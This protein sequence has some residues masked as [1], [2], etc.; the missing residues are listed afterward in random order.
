MKD[1]CQVLV[2]STEH[3]ADRVDVY[4]QGGVVEKPVSVFD[5]NK[6]KC[7]TDTSNQIKSYF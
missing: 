5:N 2:L 1:E 7:F 6:C 3:T 4:E